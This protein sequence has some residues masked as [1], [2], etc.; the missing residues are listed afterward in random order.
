M[1]IASKP[2]HSFP[3]DLATFTILFSVLTVSISKYA[4]FVQTRLIVKIEKD[5]S[6]EPDFFYIESLFIAFH[7][8]CRPSLHCR[9]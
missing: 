7:M 3:Y 5:L 4:L 1:R 2:T 9:A 6:C 8:L